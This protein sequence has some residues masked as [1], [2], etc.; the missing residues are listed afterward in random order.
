MSWS[1]LLAVTATTAS[2]AFSLVAGALPAGAAIPGF[3]AAW[4]AQSAYASASAGQVVQMSAVYQNN[5]EEP[6][7]KGTVGRQ[8]NFGAGSTKDPAY[9]RDTTAYAAWSTGQSWLANNRFAAQANDLV[10]TSQLGSWIWSVKV[11]AGQ[12]AGDVLFHGTPVVDGT[13]WMEDYGFFLKVTVS[14]GPVVITTSDPPSPSA[15]ATPTL[16]GTGAGGACTVTIFDG[17]ASVA[18]TTSDAAGS[19]SATVGPLA[20]GNHPFTATADCAGTFKGSGGTFVYT[21]LSGPPAGQASAS[22]TREI[23]FNFGQC[24][25][26]ASSAGVFNT[27]GANDATNIANYS[28]DGGATAI[29][30]VTMDASNQSV[31]ILTT[32]PMGNPSGHTLVASNVAPCSGSILSDQTAAFT[33]NDT[34]SPAISSVTASAVTGGNTTDV[35][36]LWSEPSGS[37]ATTCVGTYSIDS[38]TVAANNGHPDTSPTGQRQCALVAAAPLNAGTVHTLAVVNETDQGANA[39]TPNPTS[40]SFSVSTIPNL[41]IT[42]ASAIAEAKVRVTWNGSVDPA[43]GAPTCLS[44]GSNAIGCSSAAASTG[45]PKQMDV[46]LV[47]PWSVA[48]CGDGRTS[49][50]ITMSFSGYTG[51]GGTP[52][53][54]PVTQ[55]RTVSIV[56]DTTKPTMTAAV[57]V[58]TT[59]N[60]FD[61]TWSEDVTPQGCN[62]T[63]CQFRIKSGSTVIAS[64]KPGEGS[65]ADLGVSQPATNKVRLTATSALTAGSYTLEAI[66]GAVQDTSLGTNPNLLA[67]RTLSVVD[68]VRPTF[69]AFAPGDTDGDTVADCSAGEACRTFTFQ[70]SEKMVV[71]PNATGSITNPS[72]YRLNGQPISGL[73]SVNGAWTIATLTLTAPAD[74]PVGPNQFQ[75]V[76]AKDVGGNLIIDNLT[77]ASTVNIGFT[78]TP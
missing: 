41:A 49:C 6:W 50:A 52:L 35:V 58:G 64:T 29:T 51:P 69:V 16:S 77:G 23:V 66:A 48:P 38:I 25:Q 4:V 18:T 72:T 28:V 54:S 43:S 11:P 20:V 2:I 56:K 78:R 71:T 22:N 45:D 14:A 60:T 76:G 53:M 31:T 17:S 40:R 65:T 62:T 75:I 24:V 68:S 33:V 59:Q 39:Q 57:Q 63:T 10:A 12:P 8:A 3:H 19:F 30:R 46:T 27:S 7:V 70:F 13:T 21:V 34:T 5:G 73:L 42:S 15:L 32:A 37:N 47:T 26:P 44:P 9:P 74:A 1:R 61:V 55:T 67:T 36:V